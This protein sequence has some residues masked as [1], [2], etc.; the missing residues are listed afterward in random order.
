MRVIPFP[1][2]GGEDPS[3]LWLA[4]LESELNG[5]PDVSP[6]PYWPQL[7]ED[8]RVL[9]PPMSAE[10]ERRLHERIAE[11]TARRAQRAMHAGARGRRAAASQAPGSA[12]AGSTPT[13]RRSRRGLSRLLRQGPLGAAAIAGIATALVAGVIIAAPWRGAQTGAGHV[14]VPVRSAPAAPALTSKGTSAQRAASPTPAP[15]AGATPAPA[16][17]RV[18]QL[19]A[20][21]SLAPPAN[22]VQAIAD[23]VAQLAASDGGFVQSSHV[24]VQQG[25]PSEAMLTLKLPSAKLSAALVSLARLAPVRSQT[26]ALQD[27]TDAYDAARRHLA[28]AVAERQALLRALAAAST[29]GQIESLHERLAQSDQTIS[30]ARSGLQAIS[31]RSSTSEVE[32]TVAGDAHPVSEGLTLHRGLHDASRVLVVTLVV[33]LIAAAVIVPLALLIAGLVTGRRAWSRYQR[34]RALDSP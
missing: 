13:G 7:R 4:E 17:G 11:Q 32:V 12:T 9:A 5:D 19:A 22:E 21:I 14:P 26:Q 16:P 3:A 29:Q 30:E 33:L 10:F 34:E 15:F 18:Q 1:S 20:S 2:R 8:V 24:Q 6:Q 28:D 23:R 27:I 31:A 25:G